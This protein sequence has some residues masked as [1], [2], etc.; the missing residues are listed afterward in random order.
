LLVP[1][2]GAQGGSVEQVVK[3]GLNS[4]K[5]GLIIN[6]ARS[7]IFTADPAAEAQLLRDEINHYRQGK[8]GEIT[9]GRT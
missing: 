8:H 3:A 4:D 9:S 5:R 1:G 6:A 7:V 2:I